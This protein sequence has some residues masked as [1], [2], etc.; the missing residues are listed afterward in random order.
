MIKADAPIMRAIYQDFEVEISPDRRRFL[1]HKGRLL[2]AKY[3]GTKGSGICAESFAEY[4]IWRGEW[5]VV[6]DFLAYLD[7]QVKS[8]HSHISTTPEIDAQLQIT[9]RLIERI[10]HMLGEPTSI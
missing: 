10:S 2:Y 1:A 7:E 5:V 4:H 8:L 6:R 9:D 3:C